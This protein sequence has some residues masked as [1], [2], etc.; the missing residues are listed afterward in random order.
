MLAGTAVIVDHDRVVFRHL[1]VVSVSI[2]YRE[3]VRIE[4]ARWWLWGGGRRYLRVI[5]DEGKRWFPLFLFSGG[6]GGTPGT[7]LLRIAAIVLAQAAQVG[8]SITI[9]SRGS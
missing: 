4:D 9:R 8:T 3:A 6:V 1:W 5:T 7:R 2:P